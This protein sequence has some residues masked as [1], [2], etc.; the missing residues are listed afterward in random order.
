MQS[1]PHQEYCE[2]EPISNNGDSH[3]LDPP[4]IITI[5]IIN[6]YIE[7]FDHSDEWKL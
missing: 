1:E 6:Y 4:L 7:N 2:N 3:G 5:I